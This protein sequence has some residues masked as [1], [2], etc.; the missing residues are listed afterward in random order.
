MQKVKRRE[1][2]GFL[3]LMIFQSSC[4]KK[5]D[6]PILKCLHLLSRKSKETLM[7]VVYLLSSSAAFFLI[8]P[9]TVVVF[10]VKAI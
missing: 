10:L 1:I 2:K 9:L 6:S 8:I 3:I 4:Y 5:L 7:P